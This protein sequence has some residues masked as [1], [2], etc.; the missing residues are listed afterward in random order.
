M[1][2]LVSEIYYILNT[3]CVNA[4]V[5]ENGEIISFEVIFLNQVQGYKIRKSFLILR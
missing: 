2:I 3:P 1:E 4:T 5:L